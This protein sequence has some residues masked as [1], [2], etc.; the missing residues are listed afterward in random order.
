MLDVQQKRQNK[1]GETIS[2]SLF[3]NAGKIKYCSV[4]SM[5]AYAACVHSSDIIFHFMNE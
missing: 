1:N 3:D 5:N 2:F 4:C